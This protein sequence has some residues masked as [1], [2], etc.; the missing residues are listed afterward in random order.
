MKVFRDMEC[1]KCEAIFE[2]FQP[3]NSPQ[4]FIT[5]CPVCGLNCSVV[6][7]YVKAPGI[8]FGMISGAVNGSGFYETDNK[9]SDLVKGRAIEHKNRLHGE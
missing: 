8:A 3:M 4:S 1:S 7:V 9:N 5:E 6:R 2:D